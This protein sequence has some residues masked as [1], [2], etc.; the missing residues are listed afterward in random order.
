M[1]QLLL[2]LTTALSLLVFGSALADSDHHADSTAF[3]QQK[4]TEQLYLLQGRGGNIG[5][6]KG[7]D[8]IV[9]IDDD[10]KDLSSA[11]ATAL[12]SHGGRDNL[13]YIINT[14]WHG[15]HT[16]GNLEFGQNAVIIAHENVRKRLSTS[17]EIKLFNMKSAPYPD[18]ALP[19]VTFRQQLNL[20]I[21]D[22]DITLLHLS[23]GHTD[24]D[25]IVIFKR[26]NTVHLGDHYFAGM[27]P[28]IDTA[29]GGNVVSM[30]DNI[31]SVLTLIDDSTAVI[32]GHG[33]LASKQDLAGYRDMLRGTTAEV[34][35]MRAA[36]MSLTQMQAQGLSQQWQN[37]GHGFIKQPV[38]ISIVNTSLAEQSKP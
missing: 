11:L 28:F 2:T 10:Y 35:T 16:E 9:L 31:D 34:A 19:S 3:K 17:Q 38:W 24:G 18:D 30:A 33:P 36:G 5:L 1:T 29:T 15:D 26:A 23:N 37:W 32:P 6:L 7:D 27:F 12:E 14:H 13:Q 25:S 22:E 21:N 4:I 20:H 8:G